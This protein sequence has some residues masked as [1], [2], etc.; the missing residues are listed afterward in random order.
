MS[1]PA[2]ESEELAEAINRLLDAA[3][4]FYKWEPEVLADNEQSFREAN[5]AYAEATLA[6]VALFVRQREERET[7]RRAWNRSD[8]QIACLKAEQLT[9]NEAKDVLEALFYSPGYVLKAEIR[10]KLSR[11]RSQP[12]TPEQP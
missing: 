12:D 2:E 9:D 7:Y 3:K 8:D 10:A 4:Q 5:S 11:R 1:K 6:V